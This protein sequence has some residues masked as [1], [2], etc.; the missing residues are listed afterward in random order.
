[1]HK[2]TIYKNRRCRK[3]WEIRWLHVKLLSLKFFIDKFPYGFTTHTANIELSFIYKK[4]ILSRIVFYSL[5]GLH[6]EIV[7]LPLSLFFLLTLSCW[8]PLGRNLPQKTRSPMCLCIQAS[9]A[10]PSIY[11]PR[12]FH[13]CCD[14]FSSLLTRCYHSFCCGWCFFSEA[15][16]EVPLQIC[17]NWRVSR[18]LGR[19]LCLNI[20]THSDNYLFTSQRYFG[21]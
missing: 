2:Y 11:W 10:G 21:A 19:N 18:K 16:L 1:M 4:K 5:D 9:F 15:P 17:T 6:G 12:P 3:G 13:L 8:H 14:S 20:F 7:S